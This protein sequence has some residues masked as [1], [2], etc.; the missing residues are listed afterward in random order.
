MHVAHHTL[1]D[2][3]LGFLVE[4]GT[5]VLGADLNDFPGL[6]PGLDD[7]EALFDGVG[8]GFFDVDV[9]AGLERRDG[10]IVVQVLR[11]HDIDRVDRLIGQ[12]FA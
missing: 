2:K 4:R 12:Q 6:L 10:H 3:F 11:R 9:F 8:Q 7:V 1:L 5:A